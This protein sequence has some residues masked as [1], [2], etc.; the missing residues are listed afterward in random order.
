M[1][2]EIDVVEIEPVSF[3]RVV[4]RGTLA[5]IGELAMP[6]M[7]LV[8]PMLREAGAPTSHNAMV[9]RQAGGDEFDMEIGVQLTG[10]ANL[11][12]GEVSVGETPS[13]RAAH[14]R[15]LGP[16]DGLPAAYDAIRAWSAQEGVPLGA[17]GWEVYG[18]WADDPA[19]LE[20]DVYFLLG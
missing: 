13:G 18:D 15:H 8:W 11:P 7:D 5:Q 16:Y 14:T 12:P 19:K 20:T 17:V 3:A 9:Y 1:T 4:R 2:Y 6:A 10:D